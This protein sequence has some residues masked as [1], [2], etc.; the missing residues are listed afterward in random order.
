[1]TKNNIK[2]TDLQSLKNAQAHLRMQSE[3][4]KKNLEIAIDRSVSSKAILGKVGNFITS[5]FDGKSKNNSSDFRNL[6][7]AVLVPA[8]IKFFS[9]SI[10][11]RGSWLHILKTFV[12]SL[13]A[14]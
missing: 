1:M 12:N 4:H 14:K 10:S 5:R 6:A 11:S 3:F 8:T 13:F 9:K 2:I 7:L